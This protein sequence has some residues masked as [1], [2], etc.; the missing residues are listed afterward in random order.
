MA[1]EAGWNPPP[2]QDPR[3][4]PYTLRGCSPDLQPPDLDPDECVSSPCLFHIASDP[5]EYRNL[6]RSHPL[7]LARMAARLAK[8]GVAAVPPA[9]P[10]GCAPIVVD[11]AWR[12]CDAPG[13]GSVELT[14]PLHEPAGRGGGL[15][16]ALILMER[17]MKG[18]LES[19]RSE[20]GQTALSR[21]SHPIIFNLL[22]LIRGVPGPRAVGKGKPST[23]TPT[24]PANRWPL[25]R[26][27]RGGGAS[28]PESVGRTLL[29]KVLR[30]HPSSRRARAQS[31][32]RNKQRAGAGETTQRQER[33]SRLLNNDTPES[34]S[35]HPIRHGGALDFV[36]FKPKKVLGGEAPDLGKP[37][38]V[39]V[40][41][42]VGTSLPAAD[43]RSP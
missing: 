5:C 4:T 29:R 8:L 12:P 37:K 11:G 21:A 35:A 25:G 27:G 24:P 31:R 41:R 32:A 1:V 16:A 34:T 14:N 43:T 20:G 18:R 2:G 7:V 26:G 6:A 10:D 19:C 23:P 28:P 38:N 42:Y 36:P 40:S 13:T 22:A 30:P 33:S 17:N 3:S 39:G 15:K 9:A